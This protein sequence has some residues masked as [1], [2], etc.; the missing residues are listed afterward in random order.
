MDETSPHSH[1]S[2]ILTNPAVLKDPKTFFDVYQIPIRKFFLCLCNSPTQAEDQFQDFAVKFLEGAFS[3]YDPEKGRFR[4][5]LKQSLR[6]QV[7]KQYRKS[8]KAELSMPEDMDAVDPNLIQPVDAALSEF[9]AMEGEQIKQLVEQDM[10]ADELDGENHFHSLLKFAI[11]FQRVRLAATT[12]VQGRSKIPVSEIVRFL[13]EQFGEVVS[14][15]TAKQRMFRAKRAYASK[16]ISEIGVR[17]GDTSPRAI[18]AA[19]HELRLNVYIES[20]LSR[21]LETA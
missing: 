7:R 17:I 19:S 1:L 12:D 15:D 14:K 4:D 2:R 16:I 5:Y 20:E 18:R 9:D 8:K 13:G 6:H 3:K 21:R 11:D 10:H